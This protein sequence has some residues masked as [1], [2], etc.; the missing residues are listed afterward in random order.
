[1]HRQSA[2]LREL[3]GVACLLLL[4]ASLLPGSEAPRADTPASQ[5]D[6]AKPG[7]VSAEKHSASHKKKLVAPYALLFGTVWGTDNRPLYGVRVQ[8]R[9]AD[10]KKPRWEQYS[11]HNGECAF[12]VPAGKAEYVAVADQ[13]PYNIQR[14]NHLGTA[15]PAKIH[16]ENDERVDFGLHLKK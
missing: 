6:P 3:G 5:S 2:R 12:R 10:E 14:N 1:M 8:L 4:S 11:D 16:V 15:E 13:K 9:R 7:A